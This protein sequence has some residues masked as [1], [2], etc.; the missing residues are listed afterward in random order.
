MQFRYHLVIA[1]TDARCSRVVSEILNAKG[2][3][4]GDLISSC[5]V[6]RDSLKIRLF[7]RDAT[8][9]GEGVGWRWSRGFGGVANFRESLRTVKRMKR[10]AESLEG[11]WRKKYV[12]LIFSFINKGLEWKFWRKG[13]SN[14][15]GVKAFIAADFYEA[16]K[17]ADGKAGPESDSRITPITATKILHGGMEF[18]AEIFREVAANER[19]FP[20]L[21]HRRRFDVKSK[22]Y[23][24]RRLRDGSKYLPSISSSSGA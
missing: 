19:E 22:N 6:N 1:I 23:A 10:M 20:Y 15:F 2:A 11:W 7:M 24:S 17:L 21:M 12:F 13:Y 5:Q 18:S 3:L 9:N 8:V 4:R 16:G 14:A